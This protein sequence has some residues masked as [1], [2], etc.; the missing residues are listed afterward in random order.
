MV[1]IYRPD[2]CVRCPDVR[3]Y[4]ADVFLLV[5][6]FLPIRANG[7]NASA[8]TRTRADVAPTRI[9]QTSRGYRSVRTR[10]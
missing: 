6:G 4:P 2:V 10:F 3:D 5:N 1:K 8:Q 7:K 9:R